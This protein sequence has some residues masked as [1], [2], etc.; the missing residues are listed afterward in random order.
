MALKVG[1]KSRNGWFELYVCSCRNAHCPGS[2]YNTSG[3]F[4]FLIEKTPGNSFSPAAVTVGCRL[5][6]VC[7]TAV[8][9]QK[10]K[11]K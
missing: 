2:M 4:L 6:G 1:A 3:V 11:V 10:G 7:I 9:L 5:S 8:F